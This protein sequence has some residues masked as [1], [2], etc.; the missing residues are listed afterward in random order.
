MPGAKAGIRLDGA[1]P[2]N[3]GLAGFWPMVDHGGRVAR[4][5]S[6]YGRHATF[7]A[8]PAR[9][10][11]KWGRAPFFLRTPNRATATQL[12]S[13]TGLTMA[14][15]MAA[16]VASASGYHGR[17]FSSDGTTT[18]RMSFAWDHPDPAYRQ[19]WTTY[20]GGSNIVVPY[21]TTLSARQ[22]YFLAATTDGNTLSIYLD[23]NLVGSTTGSTISAG[24]GV[25]NLGGASANTSWWTG[26]AG[27]FRIWNRALTP[28]EMMRL[29]Q[30]AWAG[31]ARAGRPVP[32]F[33]PNLSATIDG[34]VPITA[35]ISAQLQLAATID[36]TIPVTAEIT[37]TLE[38]NPDVGDTHDGF[39]RRSRRQRAAEAAE[40][41]RR[42]TLAEEAVA[43]RL[44]L[45]AAMGMAAEVAE[46]APAAAVEAVQTAAKAARVAVPAV[47]D[48]EGLA[49]ARQA[50]AA[51]MA[52]VEEARQAKALADDDEEVLMLL[53]AL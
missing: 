35:E 12:P 8:T 29:Y 27:A 4:D 53:R 20:S 40:Q 42:I 44:E 34:T 1:D 47:P 18:A 2:I 22:T 24:S 36:A 26:R 5:I 11:S 15:W 3:R 49:V 7:S 6:G 50:V 17:P 30:N 9:V 43:L 31:T 46:E 38:P 37:A 16:D 23:G 10:P 13:M 28:P 14:F 32:F 19:A 48:V 45:E 21:P 33:L 41:R 52:A 51:L 25:V 39:M